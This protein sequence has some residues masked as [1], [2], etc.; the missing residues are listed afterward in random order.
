MQHLTYLTLSMLAHRLAPLLQGHHLVAAFSQTKDEL[1][2]ATD[3]PQGL[4]LRIACG[5]RMQYLV[6]VP[7]YGRARANS[8]DVLVPVVG[9]RIQAVQMAAQD[10][11]LRLVLE[12]GHLDCCLFGN[13]SN[14]IWRPLAAHAPVLRFRADVPEPQVPEHW[15]AAEDVPRHLAQ[16]QAMPPWLDKWSQRHLEA[17]GTSLHTYLQTVAAGT[18]Y[19]GL[20]DALPVLQWYAAP[21][22][23]ALPVEQALRHFLSLYWQQQD[24][25]QR[26]EATAR[27]VQRLLKLA[28]DRAKQTAQA[29]ADMAAARPPE[30]IGHLLMA[31]LHAVP[32][33]ATEAVLEDYYTD[34]APLRVKLNPDLS[35]V[36]NAQQYYARHK[37][38][39]RELQHLQA[40]LPA[41]AAAAQQAQACAAAFA[42]VHTG[43]QLRA[44]LKAW[45]QASP[46][47]AALA[48]PQLPDFRHFVH[49]GYD[50]Y[51]GR[52]ARNNDKLTMAFARKD[53][54]WLHAR[55]AQGS[56]VVIR[57]KG[58][59]PIPAE[60]V[61]FAAG[62]AAWYSKQRNSG[63]VAVLL[64]PR[65]YVRKSKRMAPGQVLVDR[66]ETLLVPPLQPP[67]APDA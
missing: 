56:H 36:D 30:E 26:Y 59:A 46:P 3:H 29:I 41:L 19:V 44:F 57:Q 65:K 7:Q 61:A 15:V 4:F 62:L 25:G 43:A 24:Y 54:L 47:S 48:A 52:N 8:S 40:R 53:D 14:V 5:N 2:L 49:R 11:V 51:V 60:V 9:Q 27:Q 16:P 1:V 63:L 12:T 28:T 31:Q 17:S 38:R 35:A 34:G 50:V 45:P 58:K 33:A 42:Q 13:R 6:A 32:P 23:E 22:L 64:T 39:Q 21:G 20:V 37:A 67:T 18:C 10:R 66:S 55:E